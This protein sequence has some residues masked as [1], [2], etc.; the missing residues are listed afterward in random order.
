M[1]LAQTLSSGLISP[2]ISLNIAYIP[3]PYKKDRLRGSFGVLQSYYKGVIS[4]M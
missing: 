1:Q 3:C 4:E 2:I